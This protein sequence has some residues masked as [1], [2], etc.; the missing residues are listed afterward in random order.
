MKLAFVGSS[1]YGN[2]GDDTYPLVFRERLPEHELIFYNSDLPDALPDDLEGIFL[3]GGGLIYC[4]DLPGL[5]AHFEYMRHYLDVAIDRGIAWGFVGCGLQVKPRGDSYHFEALGPWAP[6]LA[7]APILTVRSESCLQ[8]VRRLSANPLAAYYPDLGYLFDPIGAGDTSKRRTV[9]IVPSGCVT[10]EELD[11]V[12][13]PFVSVG[14]DITILSMGALCD[15]DYRIRLLSELYP[16]ARVITRPTPAEALATIAGSGYVV[17]GRYHALVFAR[18]ARVPFYIP[19]DAPYK[20]KQEDLRQ[21][22]ELAAG[23]IE[24]LRKFL[25]DYRVERGS[26]LA[27]TS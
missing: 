25:A 23:H 4:S 11:R 27:H 8:Q 24:R 6:Y 9:T 15:D 5:E 26:N 1:G 3:G 18:T 7:S 2:V 17:A 19:H 20:S 22:P 16:Q 10:P 12:L 14:Y 13:P 21:A